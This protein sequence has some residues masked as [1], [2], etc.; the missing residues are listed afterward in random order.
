MVAE[1]SR[2]LF[3]NS[4]RES[5]EDPRFESRSGLRSN[6]LFILH[7]QIKKIASRADDVINFGG[8]LYLIKMKSNLLQI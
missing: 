4:S 2:G 8:E 1:R 3:S 5:L 7:S 6:Y